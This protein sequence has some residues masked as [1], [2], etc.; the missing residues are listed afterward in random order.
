ML[1]EKTGVWRVED[2]VKNEWHQ[3][4]GEVIMSGLY[5]KLVRIGQYWQ[6][7][8]LEDKYKVGSL[9]VMRKGV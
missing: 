3:V 7:I 4:S 9:I 8:Q 5:G 2:F 6:I 1:I